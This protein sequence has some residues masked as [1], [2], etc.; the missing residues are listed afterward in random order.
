MKPTLDFNNNKTTGKTREE[1]EKDLW[2][3]KGER[4]ANSGEGGGSGFSI[5]EIMG[6]S[7]SV[8]GSKV[9]QHELGGMIADAKALD[10]RFSRQVTKNFM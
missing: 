4:D 1:A 6:G 10:S 9:S 2:G 5:D 7:G 3:G 8:G